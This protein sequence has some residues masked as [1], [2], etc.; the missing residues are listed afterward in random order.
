MVPGETERQPETQSVICGQSA[1]RG[2]AQRRERLSP[3]WQG[4]TLTLHETEGLRHPRLPPSCGLQPRAGPDVDRGERTEGS[5][6]EIQVFLSLS[7]PCHLPGVLVGTPQLCPHQHC[8]P[9]CEVFTACPRP[10]WGAQGTSPDQPPGPQ[11]SPATAGSASFS[12]PSL[13]LLLQVTTGP[14]TRQTV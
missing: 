12:T 4:G 1:G 2:A 8:P 7:H 3:C 13:S 9:R 5:D 10:S 14:S 11:P 6:G